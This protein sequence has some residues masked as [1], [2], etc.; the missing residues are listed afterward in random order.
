MHPQPTIRAISFDADG[1]LWDFAAAMQRALASTLIELR[2]LV[3]GETT[4]ALTAT[5]LASIRD[6]VAEG[7]YDQRATMEEIRLAAFVRTLEYLE[8]PNPALAA[9]LTDFYLERRFADIELY[10]DVIPALDT[11][12]ASYRLGL[13]SNGNT[14]P[15]RCGLGGYFDFVAFAQDYEVRKPDPRFYR[16]ALARSHHTA[17]TLIHVGDDLPNDVAGAQAAGIRAVWLNHD[18]RP[19]TTGIR[20]DAEIA[21]LAELAGVIDR[22][23]DWSGFAGG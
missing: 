1:T 7:L 4:A 8:Q 2:R 3:P 18:H 13:L 19:N 16:A 21:S 22:I 20:P 6:A 5:R 12:R 11:L 9:H 15:E 17:A 14:Y 10:P 23:R